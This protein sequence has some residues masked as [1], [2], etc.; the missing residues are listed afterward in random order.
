[1][2]KKILLGMGSYVDI[3]EKLYFAANNVP[4]FFQYDKVSEQMELLPIKERKRGG[5]MKYLSTCRFH[6]KIV[7]LPYNASEVVIYDCRDRKTKRNYLKDECP[8]S[9]QL[10]KHYLQAVSYSDFIYCIGWSDAELLCIDMRTEKVSVVDT[11]KSAIAADLGSKAFVGMHAYGVYAADGILWGPIDAKN[12]ILELNLQTKEATVHK[13]EAADMKFSTIC[14]DGSDFWL[15][16][17]KQIIVK[18]NRDTKKA[19]VIDRFPEG[20]VKSSKLEADFFCRSYY[21]AGYLYLFPL[22]ANMALKVNIQTYQAEI[23][24]QWDVPV[25]CDTMQK[26]DRETFYVE[27]YR[28]GSVK[29]DYSMIIGL[30]GII[31]DTDIFEIDTEQ[32]NWSEYFGDD[33]IYHEDLII[34]LEE[35]IDKKVCKKEQYHD[36]V[37]ETCGEKIY[38]EGKNA[39]REEL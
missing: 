6:D 8:E 25:S 24:C 13:V 2:K 20:F 15:T 16:G 3:E 11:W 29:L 28:E 14:F 4:A 7:F 10:Y 9:K 31:R 21:E 26:W 27:C 30:D 32:I 1:M 19:E 36:G 23:F 12:R 34:T 35:F 17:D 39:R 37:Y 22:Y 5:N 33:G 38:L 18:W